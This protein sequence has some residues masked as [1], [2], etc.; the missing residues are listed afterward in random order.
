[1]KASLQAIA[2][3]IGL[4]HDLSNATR[5]ASIESQNLKAA[6]MFMIQ[7]ADANNIGELF[8]EKFAADLLKRKFPGSSEIIRERL[9]STMSLRRKRF[10]YRISRHGKNPT[11][12]PERA[13]K[14]PTK[15]IAALIQNGLSMQPPAREGTTSKAS[16][17]E[18]TQSR[19]ASKVATATTLDPEKFRKAS[20][21]SSVST[22]KSVP[23]TQDEELNFPS[24]PK[25]VRDI[26]AVCPY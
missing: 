23:L 16:E 26:E 9:A 15:P 7:D 24:P 1:M 13:Q 12:V 8:K 18:S 19:I 4:L 2:Y 22:V 25:V 14:V 20:T 10:L 3:D 17:Q 11:R 6:T 21:P 5:N